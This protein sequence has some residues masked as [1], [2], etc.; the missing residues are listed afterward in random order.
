MPWTVRIDADRSIV[1]TTYAGFLDEADIH[2]AATATLRTATAEGITRLLA[3]CTT[4]EGGHS[5]FDLYEL[6]RTFA[7]DESMRKMREAVLLPATPELRE[8]VGFWESA[9]RNRGLNVR[10]FDDRRSATDWL[11]A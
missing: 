1:E 5:V 6:A 7:A 2:A 10:I 11:L 3:D 4:L 9:G 8:Q